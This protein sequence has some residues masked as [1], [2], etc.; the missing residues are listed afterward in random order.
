MGCDIT[1][2]L[3]AMIVWALEWSA[4]CSGV[5]SQVLHYEV[6]F[7]PSCLPEALS[8]YVSSDLPDFYS[9]SLHPL[10]IS[11][12]V[13]HL[14]AY[15]FPLLE[16]MPLTDSDCTRCVITITAIAVILIFRVLHIWPTEMGLSIGQVAIF[17]EHF[18]TVAQ[19]GCRRAGELAQQTLFFL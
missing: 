16:S 4:E 15:L 19:K 6:V 8:V 10:L 1:V 3:S 5:I 11:S 12:W 14:F 17:F 2:T 7:S 13:I 9:K 18:L